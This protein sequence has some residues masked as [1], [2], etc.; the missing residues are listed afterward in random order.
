M[1]LCLMPACSVTLTNLIPISL[2]A[3]CNA[4][5][6]TAT[7]ATHRSDTITR[8]GDCRKQTIN[9]RLHL[10]AR[11]ALLASFD[12][13]SSFALPELYPT[14]LSLCRPSTPSN[15]LE[16]AIY[17]ERRLVVSNVSA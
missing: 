1:V 10:R 11:L 8:A 6:R 12:L 15:D 17:I 16:V 7:R 2:F 13:Q 4:G 3:G 9:V 14:G 5:L